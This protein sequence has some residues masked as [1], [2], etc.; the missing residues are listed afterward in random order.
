MLE[1]IFS[2]SKNSGVANSNQ[3]GH[4][5]SDPEWKGLQDVSANSFRSNKI[6]KKF[7][8]IP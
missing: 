6:K 7:P 1:D 5:R 8:C 2:V 3:S 4:K